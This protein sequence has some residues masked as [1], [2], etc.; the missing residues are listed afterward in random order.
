MTAPI[1]FSLEDLADFVDGRL[2]PEAMREIEAH[3]AGGCAQCTANRAFVRRLNQA[4]HAA[5]WSAPPVW[6]HRQALQAFQPRRVSQRLGIRPH[7]WR[8]LLAAFVLVTIIFGLVYSLTPS[9]A[10]AATVAE[11]TGRVDVQLEPNASWQAAAVGES[12]PVGAAIR[13]A[14]G[15]QAALIFPGSDL[16]HLEPETLLQLT[17]LVRTNWRWQIAVA[18]ASGET[19]NLVQPETSDYRVRTDA[20]EAVATATRFGVK[21]E[22]DGSTIVT[23][24]EGYVTM[25][26]ALGSVIIL[27]G[28]AAVSAPGGMPT[29]LS[30]AVSTFSP[31][32]TESETAEALG[33][34][35]PG[36]QNNAT[37]D[38]AV[39]GVGTQ[40]GTQEDQNTPG[41]PASPWWPA[42]GAMPP[43]C[44]NCG[45]DSRYR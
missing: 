21:V 24:Q 8:P 22:A 13:T 19:Q 28:Q 6:V 44:P 1:H 17:R 18:Q 32:P 14:A 11:V 9:V 27:S 5:A 23:V 20:G 10:Y 38:G 15:G 7:F 45:A 37:D 35:V 12:F 25:Q 3:L 36:G 43:M 41:S 30:A 2:T 16:I 26:A 29:A 34:Q 42:T 33:T 4:A 39:D 40:A 31:A